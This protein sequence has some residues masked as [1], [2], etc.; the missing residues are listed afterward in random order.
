ME[1]IYFNNQLFKKNWSAI[2][3]FFPSGKS[4][5]TRI[6]ICSILIFLFLVQLDEFL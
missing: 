2:P 6:G 1:A 3:D 4:N 5:V